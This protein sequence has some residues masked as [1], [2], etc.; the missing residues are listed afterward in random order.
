MSKPALT[1]YRNVP[2]AITGRAATTHNATASI[3]SPSR[4]IP[5]PPAK[6]GFRALCTSKLA[7]LLEIDSWKSSVG[8][9][10][11]S[12]HD[13]HNVRCHLK[14]APHHL[15]SGQVTSRLADLHNS[16]PQEGH[17]RGVP[18]KNPNQPVIGGRHNGIRLTVEHRPLRRNDRYAHQAVAIFLACATTSS[19]PPCM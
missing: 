9:A 2:C 14:K 3:T 8:G 11:P 17:K 19:M 15:K 12:C 16:L 5:I 18:W 6:K 4:F 1:P 10:G 13:T 7:P